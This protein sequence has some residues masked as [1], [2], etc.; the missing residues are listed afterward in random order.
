MELLYLIKSN[1]YAEYAVGVIRHGLSSLS[2]L[3]RALS[4]SPPWLLSLGG[5]LAALAFGQTVLQIAG[6]AFFA[7]SSA[8]LLLALYRVA[9]FRPM[10]TGAAASPPPVTLM[11]PCHGA[12]PRMYQCLRSVCEQDYA[13]PIKVVF[14]LHSPDDAALPVIERLIADLPG[15]DAAVVIDP[16]RAGANPKNCNLANMMA[17]VHHDLLVIVDSDVLVTRDFLTSIT[18]P[19]SDD[20]V[21]AVTCIY[22][23]APEKNFFS[24]LG[25]L[26][27][28]D[29]FIPSVLVDLGRQGVHITYGAATAVTRRALESVG[30]FEAM[31]S[32]VAQDYVLGHELRRAGWR[33]AL[34]SE[35]VGTVVAEA[36]LASLYRHESRWIRNIRAVRSFD[37]LLWILTSGLVPIVLL[38]PVWP[39]GIGLAAIAIHLGLRT[40]LHLLLRRRIA[41]QPADTCLLPLREVCNFFLWSGS[42]V[43]RRVR[44]GELTMVTGNGLSMRAWSNPDGSGEAA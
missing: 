42:F 41:L 21:G 11:L 22:K 17:V 43:S 39:A 4:Q 19:F 7:A 9:T 20:G 33:I 26:Y 23:G 30:G 36:D 32:A 13:G 40:G 29:W 24:R 18:A 34:A 16:R 27:H 14:G 6:V 3:L 10:P 1:H 44:W 35:I 38:A 12:P 2:A 25:A 15:L 31:A 28:N 8:Y 5:I 37:R